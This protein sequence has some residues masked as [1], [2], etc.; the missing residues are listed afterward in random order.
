[1]AAKETM[2]MMNDNTF[3]QGETTIFAYEISEEPPHIFELS[4]YRI[5][6]PYQVM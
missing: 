2:L 3:F 4:N 6:E 5:K 1:M